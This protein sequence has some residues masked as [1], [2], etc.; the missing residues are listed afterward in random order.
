M[1]NAP[2]RYEKFVVPDGVKK[3]SYM[4]DTKIPNAA[5]FVF[6]REDHTVGNVL[7]MCATPP[8]PLSCGCIEDSGWGALCQGDRL[9][10]P[11]AG[12]VGMDVACAG[13]LSGV[14]AVERADSQR[15]ELR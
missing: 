8:H 15:S 11:R 5:R 13:S 4:K 9:P 12:S 2:N 10:N 14:V 6:E 7:R 1:T 3:V